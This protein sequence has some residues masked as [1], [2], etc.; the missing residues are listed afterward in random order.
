[1]KNLADY[2]PVCTLQLAG[3]S[4]RNGLHFS[5]IGTMKATRQDL[6]DIARMI[7]Y[8]AN[9]VSADPSKLDQTLTLT[10]GEHR[11]T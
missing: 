5:L 10:V 7:E 3:G 1:V 6:L 9:Q 2:R 8:A 4:V 11:G